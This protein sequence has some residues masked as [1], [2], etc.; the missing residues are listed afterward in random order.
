MVK[1]KIALV[2]SSIFWGTCA[3]AQEN[4]IKYQVNS[5]SDLDSISAV[6]QEEGNRIY[7]DDRLYEFFQKL[8]ELDSLKEGKVNIVHI[9]DS[10]IQADFFTGKM[11][12]LLQSRFG[13]GGLGFV[14]PYRLAKTNGNSIV[15][16]TSNV[17]W[18]SRRNI[19]PVNGANVGLSGIALSTNNKNLVIEMNI[20]D[21]EYSFSRMK[22]FT[23]TEDQLFNLGSTDK[24][25]SLE[26]GVPKKVNHIIKSGES[27]S[28]IARRYG[29]SVID[30]KRINKLKTSTIH[31]GRSLSIPTPEREPVVV[32]PEVFNRVDA[33]QAEGYYDFTFDREQNRIYF[34]SNEEKELYDLNG[35]VLENDRAG[36]LYHSIGVNGARYSD[37]GKYPLF[38]EQL[39][40]L[41]PDLLVL[42]M[43]TNEAFDKMSPADF[44]NQVNIFLKKVKEH[45]PKVNVLITTPPPSYFSKGNVNTVATELSN[46]LT[47]NGLENNYAVWDLYFNLGGNLGLQELQDQGML[48]RDL[49]HYSVKGYEY[50]ADLFFDALIEAYQK[51]C[52][53][54]K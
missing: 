33:T 53:K 34:Y 9:G 29:T 17:D 51:F 31:P 6:D 46:E 22:V 4:L 37:Y 18:E 38:F 45:L 40:G 11:R 35:I 12:K 16:Y 39:K 52:E 14:F 20:R 23:P 15:R 30:L 7:Y 50:S 26:S 32:N 2:L 25:L 10:H 13:N 44:Q 24:Q 27:L 41:E 5:D 42:S 19:Y 43:G 36:L 54:K 49:V 8:Y 48:A 47:I 3:F 28:S 21:N 1:S